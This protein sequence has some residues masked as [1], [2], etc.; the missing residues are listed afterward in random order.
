MQSIQFEN[1]GGA[2]ES[3]ISIEYTL[4]F[5]M[6]PILDHVAIRDARRATKRAYQR[7]KRR[8]LRMYANP[9]ANFDDQ[10]L[11]NATSTRIEPPEFIRL[12]SLR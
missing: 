12:F 7:A 1:D 10:K 3:Y 5:E 9:L 6:E 4:K 11:G 2:G 8:S